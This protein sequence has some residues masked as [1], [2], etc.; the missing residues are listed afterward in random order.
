MRRSYFGP[1]KQR[2]SDESSAVAPGGLGRTG[3]SQVYSSG[4]ATESECECLHVPL[5][6]NA[7]M[8]LCVMCVCNVPKLH[9]SCTGTQKVHVRDSSKSG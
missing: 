9:K 1:S 2:K 3:A 5:N 4:Y 8:C 7:C 6:V